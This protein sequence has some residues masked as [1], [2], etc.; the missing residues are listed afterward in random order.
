MT[1]AF[2]IGNGISRTAINL[3]WLRPHGKI[4]GCNALYRDFVPDVLVATDKP[5]AGAIQESYYAQKNRF[6]TRKPIDGLG[7]K[8]VPHE[9]YGFSSGPIATGLAAIDGHTEI[10]LIGF[11]MGPTANKQFNNVYADTEFYRTSTATPVYTGNWIKQLK[12]ISSDFPKTRFF[13][14]QGKTTAVVPDLEVVKNFIHMPMHTFLEL[15]NK[16][17]DL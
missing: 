11:D 1:K 16:Q 13:R 12:K 10:Y 14:V 8:K 7:A 4:Y 5:I 9:Y 3:E 15:I 6:Y 17:K 2:I